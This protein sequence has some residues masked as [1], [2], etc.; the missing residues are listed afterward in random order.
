MPLEDVAL[1]KAILQQQRFS[2]FDRMSYGNEDSQFAS[3]G[4]ATYRTPDTTV[5]ESALQE[6][7]PVGLQTILQAWMDFVF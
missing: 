7:L 1:F 6:D 4:S 2:D 5:T 3:D